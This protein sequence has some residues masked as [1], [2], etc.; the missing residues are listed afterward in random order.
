MPLISLFIG[1]DFHFE[2]HRENQ[3]PVFVFAYFFLS[4]NQ[5]IYKH[6]FMGSGNSR[7]PLSVIFN[8]ILETTGKKKKTEGERKPTDV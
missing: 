1:K 4:L 8:G 6:S 2:F 7:S 5:F 3:G